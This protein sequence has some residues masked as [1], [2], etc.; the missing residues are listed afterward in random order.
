MYKGI[1]TIW[2]DNVCLH[3]GVKGFLYSNLPA[4]I[5]A[6]DFNVYDKGGL[7]ILYERTVGQANTQTLTKSQW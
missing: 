7:C 3:V 2:Y 4:H 5:P 1:V 6:K